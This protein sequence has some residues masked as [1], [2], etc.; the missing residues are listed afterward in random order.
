MEVICINDRGE[1]YKETHYKN[2]NVPFKKIF[3]FRHSIQQST[4][5]TFMKE[6][7]D[8]SDI[9]KDQLL[10]VITI[11]DINGTNIT[12]NKNIDNNISVP[13]NVFISIKA[14]LF[15]GLDIGVDMIGCLLIS[16][17]KK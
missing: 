12:I 4:I 8:I 6:C 1:I 3:L 15:I 2:N 10:S 16:E 14:G 9:V 5:D 17:D 7:D 13:I 11:S